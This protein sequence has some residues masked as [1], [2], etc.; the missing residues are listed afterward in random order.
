[1][2]TDGEDVCAG[3]GDDAVARADLGVVSF[4]GLVGDPV[5][6]WVA[7]AGEEANSMVDNIAAAAAATATTATATGTATT[8]TEA[9]MQQQKEERLDEIATAVDMAA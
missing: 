5:N 3:E 8:T 9:E 1:L 2:S 7:V 4:E 6:G